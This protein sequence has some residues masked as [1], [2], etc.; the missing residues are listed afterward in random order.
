VRGSGRRPAGTRPT[1]LPPPAGLGEVDAGARV[2]VL[3]AIQRSSGN[4]AA[5]AA[6]QRAGVV[7]RSGQDPALRMA[8]FVEFLRSAA[9][10]WRGPDGH[11]DP[12]NYGLVLDL[13]FRMLIDAMG[14]GWE[15]PD[16][17]VPAATAVQEAYCGAVATMIAVAA[18]ASG[19][20]ETELYAES[21]ARM[22]MW[23]WREPHHRI[24]GFAGP[25]PVGTG[26]SDSGNV[27]MAYPEQGVRLVVL[28][29]TVRALPGAR[30]GQLETRMVV[31]D[32]HRQAPE[33]PPTVIFELQV[34]FHVGED[35]DRANP[36]WFGYGR[37]TTEA[38]QHGALNDPAAATVRFHEGQHVLDVVEFVTARV[39]DGGP[40]RFHGY[41]MQPDPEYRRELEFWAA[42][43][44]RVL[45]EAVEHTIQ[46]TDCVGFRRDQW[47][48]REHLAPEVVCRPR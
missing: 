34:V 48:A 26:V 44:S 36:S 43:W 10:R 2:R 46:R 8:N 15:R 25:V 20:P 16:E 45:S 23:A 14:P 40:P 13:W 12:S 9:E 6:L 17:R 5:A 30:I 22:P 37:N 4:G 41:P 1:E 29:D 11:P 33:E 42:G 3:H 7:Q 19:R 21:R 32:R 38:D 35:P 31:L 39:R 47:T 27:E 28:P 18:R 24:P